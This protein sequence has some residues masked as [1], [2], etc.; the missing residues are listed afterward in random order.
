MPS[1]PA[2]PLTRKWAMN[3]LLVNQ[4][5]TPGLG[6]LMGR[7][8]LVGFGQLAL[9]ATGFTLFVIWFCTVMTQ[10]YGLISD[11][12]S[13]PH[14]HYGLARLGVAIFAMAW[15]WAW[16]TSISLLR[17]ARRNAPDALHSFPPPLP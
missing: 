10:F 5:A 16:F 3:C 6:S 9:S 2:I 15:V 14:I 12:Q 11:Q 7:R 1:P 13:E 8:K 4:F 17:E